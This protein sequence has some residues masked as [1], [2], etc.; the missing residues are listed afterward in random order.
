RMIG[1]PLK[2]QSS[3]A[4]LLDNDATAHATIG[5][6]GVICLF[7][8]CC[9]DLLRISYCS[10]QSAIL[11]RTLPPQVQPVRLFHPKA[12][13]VSSG[14][15]HY[16]LPLESPKRPAPLRRKRIAF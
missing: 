8:Y 14:N 6:G 2:A 7:F 1:V 9:H 4:I 12:K 10:S 16:K 3:F 13:T 11:F 5:T 15:M